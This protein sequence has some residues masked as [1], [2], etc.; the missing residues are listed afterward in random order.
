LLL[1]TLTVAR[2]DPRLFDEVLDWLDVNGAFLNVQRL[3][4]LLKQYDFQ[5]KAQVSAMAEG[6]GRKSNYAL[7]W[8]KLASD[9]TLDRPESLFF[10]RDG[11]QFPA[12][13]SLLCSSRAFWLVLLF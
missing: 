1:L 6:L 4:N 8:K 10:M 9:Y 7:K 11:K 2:Y 5:A 13:N 12:P 3:Q